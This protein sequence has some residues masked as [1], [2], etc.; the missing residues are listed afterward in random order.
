MA[1]AI[2][3]PGLAGSDNRPH[4]PSPALEPR[5]RRRLR[6]RKMRSCEIFCRAMRGAI[7][8]GRACCDL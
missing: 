4:A 6:D 8:T 1:K 2:R 7:F 5:A 3:P